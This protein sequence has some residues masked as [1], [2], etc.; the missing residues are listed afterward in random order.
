MQNSIGI[1]TDAIVFAYPVVAHTVLHKIHE[2]LIQVLLCQA[3]LWP[4]GL[5]VCD[6]YQLFSAGLSYKQFHAV[7][8]RC[9]AEASA[10]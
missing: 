10:L 3:S 4:T 5:K 2:M 1:C 7:V 9:A 6:Q 8:N